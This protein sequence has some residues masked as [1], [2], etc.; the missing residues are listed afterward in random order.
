[1]LVMT[2]T[3]TINVNEEVEVKFRKVA[4]AK[5]GKKKGYLGRAVTEAI[6]EWA[7]KKEYDPNKHALEMLEKGFNLGGIKMKNRAKW[8]ER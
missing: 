1:M 4:K 7:E 5:Y 8:H 6:K 3:I 2:K